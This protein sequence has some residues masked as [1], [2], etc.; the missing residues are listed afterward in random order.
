MQLTR[1]V[2]ESSKKLQ[3][4]MKSIVLEY[5]LMRDLMKCLASKPIAPP[6]KMEA[7]Q[8]L[9]NL[10]LNFDGF[11]QLLEDASGTVQ[12]LTLPAQKFH[13]LCSKIITQKLFNKFAEAE[14]NNPTYQKMYTSD[15]L[16]ALTSP[17]TTLWEE[18]HLRFM[19]KQEKVEWVD[20]NSEPGA[21]SEDGDVKLTR[22]E[23]KRRVAVADRD[24]Y[25]KNYV[26][27]GD[28]AIDKQ[29]LESFVICK[30]TVKDAPENLETKGHTR[31]HVFDG[32]G[33]G[34][35]NAAFIRGRNPYYSRMGL[36][37]AKFEKA[38]QFFTHLENPVQVQ[39]REDNLG[40]FLTWDQRSDLC[41]G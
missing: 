5:K 22:K 11:L 15:T 24:G 38:T 16:A 12:N 9:L 30:T 2:L 28:D 8:K 19:P 26:L 41:W 23:A 40:M 27:A 36:D 6:A 39:N 32:C 34:E 14:Q 7:D 35:V 37:D 31:I 3:A 18:N 20:P 25:I 21:D 33:W 10:C 4:I 17:I 29:N 13:E 1:K